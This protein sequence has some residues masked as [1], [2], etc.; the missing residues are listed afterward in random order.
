MDEISDLEM[1]RVIGE[2]L[3]LGHMDNIAALFRKEPQ[4]YRLTGELVQDERFMVRMGV[5]VLFEELVTTHPEEVRQAIPSLL[6]LLT[7]PTPFIRGE[8]CTILGIINSPDA[9]HHLAALTDDPDP[10][11]REIVEDCLKGRT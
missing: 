4:W 6:P 1:V 7:D 5:A 11:I 10:Q 3:E 8:A 9:L 2:F